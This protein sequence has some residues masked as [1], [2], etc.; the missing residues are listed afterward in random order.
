M[1]N[2]IDTSKLTPE[3][4]IIRSL[5]DRIVK[6]Q[7][8]LR[9]LDAIKWGPEIQ[10]AF[11]AKDCKELPPI[12]AAYYQKNPLPFDA[13]AKKEEFYAIE[14][15]TRSQLGEI[16]SVSKM[17]QRICREYREVVRLMEARGTKDFSRISQELYGS[18]QDAFYAGAPTLKDLAANVSEILATLRFHVMTSA[19]EKRYTSEEAVRILNERLGQYFKDINSGEPR[20]CVKIS[21]GILADSAAG[22]EFIKVRAGTMFSAR[23][24]RAFEV[25]EGWVHLGTTFNGM[26]QPICTFLSKGAPS[27][28]QTQEGL[29][30]LMEFFTF[31]S[32]PDRVRRLLD[33]VTAIGM[34]EEG[35][36]F[37]D[38][39]NFYRQ[40]DF[41]DEQ[42]YAN[43]LRVFRGS[44][45]NAGPFTKDLSYSKGFVA[46]Y[47]YVRITIRQGSLPRIPILFVGK[48]T[49]E[50]I[51]TISE[52]I[53]EGLVIPPKYVPPQFDDVAGLA[54][55]MAYSLFLQRLNIQSL[56][57]NF[58]NLLP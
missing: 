46:I 47:N 28:T 24:I 26:A 37:L 35:A 58:K 25:H 56:A 55:W 32:Y 6:A 29:A 16:S 44:L 51:K 13:E 5:S 19:D 42:C 38:V 14:R 10:Q 43:A 15:E 27:S 1:A 8:P 2:E 48:T 50:D 17:M 4:A 54:G 21:D 39:F 41:T 52:M 57:A 7:R 45:P 3:Q 11:F 22:A 53:D 20:A 36:N 34:V 9:V 31:T 40:R 30:T 23:E 49:L 18:A 33:R 12:D